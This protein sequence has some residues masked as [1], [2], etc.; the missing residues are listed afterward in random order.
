MRKYRSYLTIAAT[1]LLCTLLGPVLAED[2][3]PS[4][5]VAFSDTQFGFIIN[6]DVGHGTLTYNGQKHLIHVHGG[7][8]G[9]AGI[10]G[11]DVEGTVYYLSR[12]QDFAGTYFKAQAGLTVGAGKGGA[13]LENGQGVVMHLHSAKSRGLA[14]EIGVEGVSITF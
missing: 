12:L 6:A 5:T 11:H 10:S 13:W 1:F 9:G 4:A 8:V 3:E 7:R 14:L 2:P